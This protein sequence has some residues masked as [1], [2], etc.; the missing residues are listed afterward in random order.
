MF[1]GIIESA[2]R[3]VSLEP[4]D[5]GCKLSLDLTDLDGAPVLGE[6]IAVDGVCLT[7]EAVQESTAHFHAG[8]ETLSL[9][10]LGGLK[11]GDTVNV[12]RA[13]ALGDRLG[14]HMVSGHV[15]G[16]GRITDIASAPDQTIMTFELPP[17]IHEN[18]LL[19]GSIA[20]DGISLTLMDVDSEAHLVSVAV[21]PHTLEV[22]TLGRRAVGDPVNLEADLVGRWIRSMIAPVLDEIS[23][24]N[25]PE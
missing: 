15:D 7:V 3:V 24:K 13:L 9:T 2:V 4:I 8:S 11:P 16:V 18:T 19:K 6:S 21:I 23:R 25:R 1:T 17:E 14:G 12:E 10:T 20:I 5:G 22:T